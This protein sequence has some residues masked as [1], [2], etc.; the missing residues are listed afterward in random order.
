MKSIIKE[1]NRKMTLKFGVEIETFPLKTEEY[2]RS[3]KELIK[4]DKD[5]IIERLLGN[6]KFNE[7]ERKTI[8]KLFIENVFRE[9][10][11]EIVVEEY[12]FH[13]I[14]LCLILCESEK[15]EMEFRTALG[16]KKY[17]LQPSKCEK[18]SKKEWT[19][20]FDGSVY[21]NNAEDEEDE[22]PL[23]MLLYNNVKNINHRVKDKKVLNHIE[24]VSP[25]YNSVEEVRKGTKELFENVSK[26]L[27]SN[28][29][30]FYHNVMTSN[31]IHFSPE[32]KLKNEPF[33]IFVFETLF[34]VL[35][36]LIGLLC[37]DDRYQNIFCQYLEVTERN[38]LSKITKSNYMKKIRE[39]NKK[40][41]YLITGIISNIS[42]YF[43]Q[44]KSEPKLTRY[45]VVNLM[46]LIKKNGL[47][48]IEIR[49]KH[50]T[51]DSKEI[52]QFCNFIENIF[53]MAEFIKD[54]ITDDDSVL[55]FIMSIIGEESMQFL[56]LLRFSYFFDR[57]KFI[58]EKME[59]IKN[60][61]NIMLDNKETNYWMKH[62]LL[63]HGIKSKDELSK[64]SS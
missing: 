31:H 50:G 53:V 39:E 32:F 45:S 43:K 23:E 5:E 3:F 16:E 44:D 24:F 63:L 46:N 18:D 47:G 33:L 9:S 42:F 49:I 48:T 55:Y 36:P 64:S 25:I 13:Y 7:I 56:R 26:A 10:E 20:T 28:K 40:S 41:N 35:Q 19:I 14:L 62:I 6:S 58:A 1:E 8:R 2:E 34:Y 51:N 11:K 61:L 30:M 57:K 4:G 15:N 29:G 38:H 54:R 37:S 27:K 59:E 22:I 21:F 52:A 17:L 60:V 12:K